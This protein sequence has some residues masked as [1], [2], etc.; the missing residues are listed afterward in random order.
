M[1]TL[2]R[3]IIHELFRDKDPDT[4][5]ELLDVNDEI[6]EKLGQDLIKIKEH[7]TAVLW[8]QFKENGDTSTK[9]REVYQSNIPT[10][11]EELDNAFIDLS[12]SAMTS[13]YNEIKHTNSNGGYICF[14]E[15]TSKLQE[16]MLVA[17]ITNTS[18]VKLK[19]LKPTRDLHVDI[20]KLHQAVDISI[21]GYL[22]SIQDKNEKNYLSFIGKGKHTDYFTNAFNCINKI[23][24]SKM[25]SKAVEL[26][27][28]FLSS[29]NVDKKN[30]RAAREQLV[31]Y[32]SDNVGK[33]VFLSKVEEI[34]KSH[35]PD[36]CT[37]E[38]KESFL[39]FSKQ[40]KYQMPAS[41][42]A[43][44]GPVE[45]LARLS[46][47]TDSFTFNFGIEDVGLVGKTEDVEKK[48]LFNPDNDDIVI[49]G[50]ELPEHI[51]TALIEQVDL[52]SG[53]EEND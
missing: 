15:Y 40:E 33:E 28:E 37:E 14:I 49:K 16:R 52:A 29:F 44:K 24:P 21:T 45:K 50:G 19:K 30:I 5:K 26:L 41:F 34:A 27:K 46:Y 35:L 53:T 23:T 38:Q 18:G 48:I 12:E 47:S 42:L 31:K 7:R 39:T 6:I 11:A 2:K 3:F 32:F 43:A 8:G 22:L 1:A 20:S 9:I 25:P 4:A 10:N 36:N 17:M 13:L 51:R